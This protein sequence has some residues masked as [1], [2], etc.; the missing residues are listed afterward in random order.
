MKSRWIR[1]SQIGTKSSLAADSRRKRGSEKLFPIRVFLRKSAAK[2]SEPDSL[3]GD[4]VFTLHASLF[5]V[6]HAGVKLYQRLDRYTFNFLW[7]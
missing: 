1:R 2:I 6:V 4:A 5:F 3:S 7:R